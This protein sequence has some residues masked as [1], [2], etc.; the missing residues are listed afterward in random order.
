MAFIVLGHAIAASAGTTQHLPGYVADGL[1]IYVP[2]SVAMNPLMSIAYSFHVPL[3]AFVSGYVLWRAV[4]RPFGVAVRRRAVGLLVPYFAWFCTVDL[5]SRATRYGAPPTRAFFA[6]LVSVALNPKN[7]HALWY[8]YSLFTCAVVL[9]AL[10]QLPHAR[11]V[12]ACSV[13]VAVA[14]AL[15]PAVARI[16]LL[17][18]GDSLWIYPFFAFGY[19]VVPLHR[20][21]AERSMP[22]TLGAGAVFAVLAWMRYP[23]LAPDLSLLSRVKV[24]AAAL[25]AHGIPGSLIVASAVPQLVAYGCAA[26]ACIALLAASGWVRGWALEAQAFVG[27]RA[28]GVYAMHGALLLMIARFVHIKSWPVLFV[29][30]FAVSIVAT[31]LLERIPLFGDVLLGRGLNLRRLEA[32]APSGP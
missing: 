25:Q 20:W 18:V 3:F 4:P 17:G 29:A 13:P 27:R 31:L 24:V 6:D 16:H 28:L 2:F 30:G 14:L 5:L 32:S 19:L 21:V 8:L 26:S 1:G 11:R 22:I 12:I 9:S 15:F 7:P 10:E 23:V